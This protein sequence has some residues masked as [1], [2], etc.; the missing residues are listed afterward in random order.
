MPNMLSLVIFAVDNV[1]LGIC[2]MIAKQAH[3]TSII[4]PKLV[5]VPIE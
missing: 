4:T 3:D 2:I 5:P 1:S